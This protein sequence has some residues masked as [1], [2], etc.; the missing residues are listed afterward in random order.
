MK[1]GTDNTHRV[2]YLETDIP[3]YFSYARQFTLCDKYA[4]AP[5]INN[6]AQSLPSQA[7]R[8]IEAH[9]VAQTAR[10]AATFQNAYCKIA[11]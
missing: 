9:L 1:R 8:W 11:A 6:P 4:D 7:R 2:Q 10:H 5:A 3:S